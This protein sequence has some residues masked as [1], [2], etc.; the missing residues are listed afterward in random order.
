MIRHLEY[1]RARL[2]Q[3]SVRLRQAIRLCPNVACVLTK[4][5]LVKPTEL[6]ALTAVLET[7]LAK[8]VGAMPH[9]IPTSSR[10]QDGVELLRSALAKLARPQIEAPR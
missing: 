9:P 2:A 7:R 1:T 8:T 3:T 5:D 10:S 6:E 4:T